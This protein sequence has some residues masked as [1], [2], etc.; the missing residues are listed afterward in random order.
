MEDRVVPHA[1]QYVLSVILMG[2]EYF[3]QERTKKLANQAAVQN[4]LMSMYS[5]KLEQPPS[6]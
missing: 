5:L 4:T 1:K 3:S 6:V 2:V